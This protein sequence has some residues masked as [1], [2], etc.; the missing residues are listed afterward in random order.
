MSRIEEMRGDFMK[1]I[2]L[3][4]VPDS[5]FDGIEKPFEPTMYAC[6]SRH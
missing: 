3:I 6:I 5:K 4:D 2:I 1:A